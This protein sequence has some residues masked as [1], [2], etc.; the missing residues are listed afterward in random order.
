MSNFLMQLLAK[1]APIPQP[2]ESSIVAQNIL[3]AENNRRQLESEQ[4]IGQLLQQNTSDEGADLNA[5][6]KAALEAGNFRAFDTLQ[7]L[8][9]QQAQGMAASQKAAREGLTMALNVAKVR[10]EVL[11]QVQRFLSAAGLPVENLRPDEIFELA[12][13][14][15]DD[16]L[17]MAAMRQKMQLAAAGR[18]VSS[19]NVSVGGES[20]FPITTT[21]DLAKRHPDNPGFQKLAEENPDQVVQVEKDGTI[22]LV[23][24]KGL[25]ESQAKSTKFA[26]RAVSALQHLE[27]IEIEDPSSSSIG[28]SELAAS[29]L[30]GED[31]AN[32]VRSDAR[33]NFHNAAEMWKAAVLRD[34]SGAVIGEQEMDRAGR[35][36]FPVMG[37]S[38][39]IRDLKRKQRRVIT[40]SMA[41]N[42][43]QRKKAALMRE[44][45]EDHA[46]AQAAM[47]APQ[48]L[49]QQL[50]ASSIAS[51]PADPIS[52]LPPG[53]RWAN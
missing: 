29:R 8:K 52:T 51:P 47:Q 12:D 25:S 39:E 31:A 1:P 37:D 7:K 5:V 49:S 35:M 36:Y 10:P 45:M 48:D 33:K 27:A 43:P 19:V 21:G 24:M 44:L 20:G 17:S 14:L 30:G 50:G 38:L 15:K 9:F 2:G 28:L 13:S 6:S 46:A 23:D 22:K 4:L 53:S 18:S 26:E 16:T 11:P 42:L 34:E 40:E 41:G 3:G 32:L